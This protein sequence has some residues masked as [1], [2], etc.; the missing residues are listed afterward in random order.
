MFNLLCETYGEDALSIAHVF[1]WHKRETRCGREQVTWPFSNKENW[2]K[3]GKDEDPCENRSP[4]RHQ[5]DSRRVE[6]GQIHGDKNLMT[7]FNVKVC[8]K[9]GPK[10]SEWILK[11][12][13]KRV[14]AEILEKIEEDARNLIFW[15]P[16][17]NIRFFC[18]TQKK[19]SIHT[20][21]N[22]HI[23]DTKGSLNVELKS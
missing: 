18:I 20:M 6:H 23:T 12:G 4:F 22:S 3:Y 13:R 8:V 15:S 10:E 11:L 5:N 17:K 1:E 19:A 21:E 2:W 14:C 7:D 9:H 16:A